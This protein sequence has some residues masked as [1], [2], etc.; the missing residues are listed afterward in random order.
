MAAIPPQQ[1]RNINENIN[2]FNDNESE[3]EAISDEEMLEEAY[4]PRRRHIAGANVA[5]VVGQAAVVANVVSESLRLR[6]RK[7]DKYMDMI[8][9]LPFLFLLD[10]IL[11]QDMGWNGIYNHTSRNFTSQVVKVDGSSQYLNANHVFHFHKDPEFTTRKDAYLKAKQEALSEEYETNGN[12]TYPR[13]SMEP[14][15]ATAAEMYQSLYGNPDW[16][17]LPHFAM[18]YCFITFAVA[19]F[20]VLTLNTRQLK[21]FYTYL[22]CISLVPIS[23]TINIITIERLSNSEEYVISGIDAY[24]PTVLN[25][26]M[27]CNYFVQAAIGYLSSAL[28]RTQINNNT[29]WLIS[30]MLPFS[31]LI[32]SILI[33]VGIELETL[34]L[35]ALVAIIPPAAITVTSL[36]FGLKLSFRSVRH[37]FKNKYHILQHFGLSTFL[38]T[39]WIRLQVPSLLRTFWLTRCVQQVLVLVVRVVS[40]SVVAST[41]TLPTLGNITAGII[42]MAKDLLTRGNET[43]MAVLGM[44]S[45]VAAVCHY[46]GSMFHFVL[47]D[48]ENGN[49]GGT[50]NDEEKSVGS[51]SAVLFFVLA[52]QT[53]LTSLEPDKRFAR[54]CKNLCLLVTALFHFVHN[55]ASPVLMSL[56]AARFI[57]YRR[58][59]RALSICL[60]LI[61]APLI[62][63]A[64]LWKLF[65]VGTWLLAVSAFCVEVVVKGKK[66]KTL[67]LKSRNRR[68]YIYDYKLTKE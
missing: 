59:F 51:V 46:I 6:S 14:V 15:E 61:C 56:S 31:I 47:T 10:Q 17:A 50:E 12:E 11:L 1:A 42:N 58:H 32:P 39:E 5:D 28:L 52:L 48:N 57:N 19:L 64:V 44:T 37:S 27:I 20:I 67:I 8:L 38:E 21:M 65:P 34:R 66:Y 36:W 35:A 33:L 55:M 45:I 16:V 68:N 43:T 63:M 53:G 24:L 7:W 2:H 3:S 30:D 13:S 54:L 18:A 62:L 23:Y 4:L 25:S 29:H 60:F 9:R 41:F 40:A 22:I 49:V 26:L